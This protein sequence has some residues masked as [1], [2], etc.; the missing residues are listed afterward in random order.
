MKPVKARSSID[1]SKIA[2]GDRIQDA[3]GEWHEVYE[4]RDNIF[5]SIDGNAVHKTKVI[6]WKPQKKS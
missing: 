4:V 1:K 6:G 3:F 5:Y 2:P